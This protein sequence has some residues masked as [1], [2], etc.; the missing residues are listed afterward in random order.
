MKNRVIKILRLR[1]KS[2]TCL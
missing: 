1:T 2:K